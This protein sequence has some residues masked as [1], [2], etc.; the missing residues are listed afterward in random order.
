MTSRRRLL[1]LLAAGATVGPGLAR[2]AA[3]AGNQPLEHDSG[4]AGDIIPVELRVEWRAGP[5]GIDTR[6]PR[7]TWT[8]E[9]GPGIRGARQSACQAILASS[10]HAAKAGHG[11]IWDSGVLETGELRTAAGNSREA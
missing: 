11:D 4:R 7:L 10:E 9:A 8:L 2:R 6:R 1:K 3:N 5:I